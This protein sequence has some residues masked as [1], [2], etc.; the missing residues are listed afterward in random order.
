LFTDKKINKQT[1]DRHRWKHN[2]L[3]GWKYCR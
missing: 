1:R 3:G 2:L